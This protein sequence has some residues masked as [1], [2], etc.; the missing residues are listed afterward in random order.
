[1]QVWWWILLM[2]IGSIYYF[3]SKKKYSKFLNEMS[4]QSLE[5]F[6]DGWPTNRRRQHLPSSQNSKNMPTSLVR[7]SEK[8]TIFDEKTPSNMMQFMRLK[9]SKIFPGIQHIQ[10]SVWLVFFAFETVISVHLM[11]ICMVLLNS[12]I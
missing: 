3:E 1:M 4:D 2:L 11:W 9:F 6:N 8:K 10:I 7:W 12:E 5:W